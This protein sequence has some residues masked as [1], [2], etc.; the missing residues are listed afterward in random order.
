MNRTGRF[1]ETINGTKGGEVFSACQSSHRASSII[2]LNCSKEERLR[3]IADD[4][5]VSEGILHGIV[6]VVIEAGDKDAQGSLGC[7]GRMLRT[8]SKPSMS[9]SLTSAKRRQIKPSFPQIL[10]PLHGALLDHGRHVAFHLDEPFE[11]PAHVFVVV[12]DQDADL[13]FSG[14]TRR[15]SAS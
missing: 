15:S 10:E 8:N 13:K 7:S 9:G 3:K 2:L 11:R 6:V 5:T 14:R 12:H 1:A 4:E